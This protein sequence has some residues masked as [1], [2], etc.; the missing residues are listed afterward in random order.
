LPVWKKWSN[1]EGEPKV[2]VFDATETDIDIGMLSEEITSDDVDAKFSD[3]HS[4]LPAEVRN[5]LNMF[6]WF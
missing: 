6:D 2:I 3:W 5:L 4:R 1:R